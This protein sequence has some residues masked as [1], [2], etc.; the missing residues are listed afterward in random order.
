MKRVFIGLLALGLFPSVVFGAGFARQ[1][2]FLSKTQVFEGDSVL[3]HTIV[4]N[5]AVEKFAGTLTIT[6]GDEKIGTVPVALAA[7]EAQAISISWKPVAGSHTLTATLRDTSEEIAEKT[8][9]TFRVNQK[10]QPAD[11]SAGMS[12]VESSE[13]IQQQLANL[14]P[15]VAE[16]AAPVF[17][18]VDS[19]RNSAVSTIDKGIEWAEEQTAS[20]KK[21]STAGGLVLGASTSTES[22]G[23]MSTIWTILATIALHTLSI[24]RYIIANPAICYPLFAALFLYGLWRLYK[25]MR[26]PRFDA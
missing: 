2:I 22:G 20:K 8:T 12:G 6:E 25:R 24:L 19:V 14:S 9:A 16:A 13:N 4:A 26:A 10:P 21:A 5:E 15:G 18:S 23:I 11:E 7:Q 3:V 1:S 17:S